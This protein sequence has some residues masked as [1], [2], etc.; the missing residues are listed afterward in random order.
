MNKFLVLLLI[1]F[2]TITIYSSPVHDYGQLRVEGSNIVDLNGQKIALKGISLGW[3][4]WWPQYYNSYVVKYLSS[5]WR[6]SVIRVAMG[7]ESEGG[8]LE[9]PEKSKELIQNVI[10]AA[11][12]NGIYV[13]V[14]WHS[15]HI[16]T[17][18][19]EEFFSYISQKYSSYPNIIYEIFN[20]PENISWGEVKEYSIKLIE[21]IRKYDKNNLIIVGTPNWSQ[22]VDIVAKD[23][24]FGYNNIVYSLHFY[25]ASHL[26][27]RYKAEYAIRQGLPLFVS[28]CSPTEF[29][30]DG[31]LDKREFKRW[32]KFM[33]QNNISFVLWGLYDK[34]ESSSMLKLGANDY[35]KWKSSQLTEMGYYSKQMMMK[36]NNLERIALIIGV[37]FVSIIVSFYIRKKIN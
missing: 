21:T 3:H 5:K 11:I 24:I 10:D 18:K 32:L 30:G 16:F 36:R 14:D 9:N 15:H 17:E 28:E 8:Y 23:P 6:I 2:N 22:D 19:S 20:E 7:V 37:F 26:F 4:N 29:N 1:M 35:G 31:K 27:V 12:A 33:K 13:I 25:A 34:E